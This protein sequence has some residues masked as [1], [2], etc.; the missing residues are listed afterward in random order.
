VRNRQR[1]ANE[2]R[3]S[4]RQMISEIGRRTDRCLI[5]NRWARQT[6]IDR[7]TAKDIQI[8]TES[9]PTDRNRKM[10]RQTVRVVMAKLR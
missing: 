4:N 9:R 6:E 10:A 2:N 7:P 1:Q 5:T 8:E 3:E